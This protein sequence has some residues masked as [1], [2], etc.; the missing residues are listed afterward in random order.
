MAGGKKRGVAPCLRC[1][2]CGTVGGLRD[3]VLM[4]TP[5]KDER[6]TP[7]AR[8]R[9]FSPILPVRHLAHY[10]SLGF[11]VTPYAG[12]GFHGIDHDHEDFAVS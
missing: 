12:G 4:G 10:A 8:L 11:D 2:P 1:V 9:S 7:P 5:L 3:A 6:A